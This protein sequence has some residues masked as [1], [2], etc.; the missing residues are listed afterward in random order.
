[1][2]NRVT[3]KVSLVRK[4][5]FGPITPPS[6]F[7]SKCETVFKE[8]DERIDRVKVEIETGVEELFKNPSSSVDEFLKLIED[9]M[10]RNG[11]PNLSPEEK[12]LIKK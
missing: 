11:F 8:Y 1:M 12:A 5:D 2:S 10:D 4:G 6:D 7:A 9:I 3:R